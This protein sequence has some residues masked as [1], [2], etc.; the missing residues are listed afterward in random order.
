MGIVGVSIGRENLAIA[1]DDETCRYRKRP[2]V[3][4]VEPS[5]VEL[6]GVG[7]DPFELFRDLEDQT[8]RAGDWIARVGED[9]ESQ[10]VTLG[11]LGAMLG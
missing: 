11:D 10:L 6:E 5:Q 3:V 9:V 4:T 8:P 1:P 2:G 7:V